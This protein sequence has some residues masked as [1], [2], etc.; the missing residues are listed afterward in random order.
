[1]LGVESYQKNDKLSHPMSAFDRSHVT[2]YT[3][4]EYNIVKDQRQN[5]NA[6]FF[7]IDSSDDKAPLNIKGKLDSKIALMMATKKKKRR[8]KRKDND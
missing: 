7:R 6:H 4:D 2:S 3:D 5:M 1:L 8:S